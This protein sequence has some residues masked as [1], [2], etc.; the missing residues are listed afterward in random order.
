MS[1]APTVNAEAIW[2]APVAV[3]NLTSLA[4]SAGTEILKVEDPQRQSLLLFPLLHEANTARTRPIAAK[5]PLRPFMVQYPLP[6]KS[7]SV[8]FV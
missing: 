7:Y 5:T 6:S 8:M 2:Q 1:F 3:T 4:R